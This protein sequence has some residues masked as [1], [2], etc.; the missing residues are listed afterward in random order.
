MA[1]RSFG[2][3]T[4]YAFRTDVPNATPMQIGTLQDVQVDFSGSSKDLYG[5]GQYAEATGR[6]QQKITVKAKSGRIDG[7]LFNDLFF[8]STLETGQ[9]T[10]AD[11]ESATVPAA[12]P[13]TVSVANSSTFVEDL[14]VMNALNGMR[15]ELVASDPA[16]GQYS[17]NPTTGEYTFALADANTPLSISYLYTAITGWSFE[18]DQVDQGIQPV[19]GMVLKTKFNGSAGLETTTL[20]LYSCISD[21]LSVP[22]KSADWLIAELDFTANANAAGKVGKWSGNN[23]S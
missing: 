23:V 21:K 19:F 16:T 15:F 3:G 5:S 2:A 10:T 13:Y 14:G 6:G 20:E 22:T 7:R 12:T 9:D 11:G 1:T 4:L 17:V 8:G 18:I